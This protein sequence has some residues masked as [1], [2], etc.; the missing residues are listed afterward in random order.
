MKLAKILFI[1][2][3]VV[4]VPS[5]ASAQAPAATQTAP[6]KVG[7]VNSAKFTAATGGITRLVNAFRTLETEFKPKRDEITQLVSRLDALRQ[8][9]AG[10]TQAQLA[11]RRDQ[12]ETLQVEITRKQ[13]DGR[14]AYSRRLAALTEPIRAS[15]FT[16]LE[17]FAKQRGVDVLIDISKFPDGVLLLNQNADLTDAFIRDYNSKNP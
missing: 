11:T 5:F 9:P 6:A 12:A 3:T 8:V 2:A 16:A 7:L 15:I 4:T 17:A 14:V 13:E 1:L 10:T